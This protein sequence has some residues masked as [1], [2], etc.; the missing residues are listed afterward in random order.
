MNA[1]SRFAN[2]FAL[3]IALAG[4]GSVKL[5]T[6]HLK[7]IA[8]EFLAQVVSGDV[9]GAFKRHIR[10]D[11]VHHNPCFHGDAASLRIGM[12]ED[13]A[14]NPGK[15]MDIQVALEDGNYVAVHSRLHRA[16][17][18]SEIS[19]VHIF[20]FEQKRII[21]LW[22]IVQFVPSQIVDMNGMF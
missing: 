11:F 2:H 1:F 4:Q 13:E 17:S 14:A 10:E 19:V 21:E 7:D 8:V 15:R 20:R 6:Q 12:E 22:D 18:E 9:A 3:K 16:D 5:T